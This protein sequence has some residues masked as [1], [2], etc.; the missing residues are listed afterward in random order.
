MHNII[1]YFNDSGNDYTMHF[2]NDIEKTRLVFNQV[3]SA[4]DNK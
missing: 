4:M 1:F 2:N 3:L